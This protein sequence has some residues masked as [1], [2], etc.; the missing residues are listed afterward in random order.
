MYIYIQYMYK[1]NIYYICIHIIIQCLQQQQ[2]TQ[3]V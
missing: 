2:R 3:C 1:Y